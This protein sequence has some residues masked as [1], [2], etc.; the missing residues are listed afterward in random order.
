MKTWQF[1]IIDNDADFLNTRGEI[2]KNRFGDVHLYSAQSI[3]DAIHILEREYI[4]LAIVDIRLISE[5]DPQDVSGLNFARDPKYRSVPKIIL[6]AY[7]SYETARDALEPDPNGSL[8]PAVAFLSKAESTDKLIQ[9]IQDVLERYVRINEDLHIHWRQG[10][11][12]RHWVELIAAET[13]EEKL[14]ERALELEDLFRKLF[15]ENEQITIGR[16]LCAENGQLNVEVFAHGKGKL[17]GAYAVSVGRRTIIEQERNNYQKYKPKKLKKGV[18]HFVTYQES[19]R[20]GINVYRLVEGDIEAMEGFAALYARHDTSFIAQ[21]LENVFEYAL[22]WL[23]EQDR[24]IRHGATLQDVFL[25]WVGV[26]RDF[27]VSSL[28]EKVKRICDISFQRNLGPMTAKETSITFQ[29]P[30]IPALIFPNPTRIA[31]LHAMTLHSPVLYAAHHGHLK[32][33]AIL[34]DPAGFAWLINFHNLGHG[35]VVRD[36]VCLES[37]LLIDLAGNM[38]SFRLYQ[39]LERLSSE[40][41]FVDETP[42]EPDWTSEQQKLFTTVT[43]LRSLAY[44]K[45]H[46]DSRIYQMGLLVCALA[47]I[48]AFDLGI[49][50]YTRYEIVPFARALLIASMLYQRL[51]STLDPATHLP[52]QALHSLW[53]DEV[54]K[55]VWV[56]GEPKE[57]TPQ[58][59]DIMLFL[60][61]RKGKLCTRR[62]ILKEALQE[63]LSGEAGELKMAESR[64][65]SAMTRLRQK[66]E[67]EPDRPKYIVT[68]RG[69]GYK[70]IV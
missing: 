50:Y 13:P 17:S 20:F 9:T 36:F 25:D 43:R 47:R 7:P 37:A 49:K 32:P 21:A 3:T 12:F 29:F 45:A 34:A 68:I 62:D 18:T 57:L 33:D 22:A 63:P 41:G 48:D 70:L 64:L 23:H 30:D 59:T 24:T 58:E 5:D 51:I 4:H 53:V 35:P 60:W 15:Y 14:L 65:N 67:P 44:K 19:M 8:P 40:D 28:A 1:I 54:N 38:D 26:T 66:I 39:V 69:Q 16:I 56:E 55:V 42:S 10:G 6:T 2:I 31:P 61:R 11:S 46:V 52:S 27:D